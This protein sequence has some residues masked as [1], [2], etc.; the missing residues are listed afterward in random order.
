MTL[1]VLGRTVAD[2]LV[3]A[4]LDP[5]GGLNC[6]PT[7]DTPL[8][9]GMTITATDVF[10]RITE[11]EIALPYVLWSRGTRRCLSTPARS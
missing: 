6:D 3:M 5:T 7:V 1:T 8:E 9:S 4:G 10:F 11:E 2:A